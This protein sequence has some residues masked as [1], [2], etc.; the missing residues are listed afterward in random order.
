[1]FSLVAASKQEPNAPPGPF[2]IIALRLW[3]N[4]ADK[5][6]F[7]QISLFDDTRKWDSLRRIR[8]GVWFRQ[9]RSRKCGI[10]EH[11]D[12]IGRRSRDLSDHARNECYAGE[13]NVRDESQLRELRHRIA[14]KL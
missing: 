11:T 14:R 12:D 4:S 8:D 1:V 7:C 6:H 5:W 9:Q 3:Q 10:F 13:D 2:H